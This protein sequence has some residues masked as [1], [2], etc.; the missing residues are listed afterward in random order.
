MIFV[1]GARVVLPENPE[2]GW[3]R[4]RG[5]IL[6]VEELLWGTS[7][8]VQVDKQYRTGDLDDGLREVTAEQITIEAE[9]N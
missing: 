9:A 3:P 2:E 1:E 6:D 7:V 4:E 5:V 8:I